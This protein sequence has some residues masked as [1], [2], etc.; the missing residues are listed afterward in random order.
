MGCPSCG[1]ENPSGARFCNSCGAPQVVACF[2]CGNGNPPASRFCNACGSSLGVVPAPAQRDATPSPQSYT[3]R[4]LAEKILANRADLEGERKQV[5]VLFADVVGSTELIR[6]RDPED[7]QRLL[8]GIVKVMME[9]VHRYE[10]TVSRLTGDGLMAM[11]GAPVAHEDHAV[12][13]CYAALA[14]LE[15]A[16]GHA[17][18]LRRSLGVTLTI[19]VGLSSGEV[20]VRAIRDDLHMDYTAMGQTVH[21]AS[22]MEQLAEP[23]TAAFTVETLALVEGYV[24][25]RALGPVPVKGLD[26]PVEIYQLLGAGQVRSRFQAAA[27]RGLTR[28]VGRQTE[29][30]ALYGALDRARGGDG[31][32]AALVGEP[33]VGKSRLVWELTHSHHV[34]GW[35]ILESGSV[36]YGKTTSYLP[37]IDLLKSYCRIETRDDARTIREKVLGK[38]LNLDESL[39]T[40]LPAI[41]T[42]LDVEV[43]DES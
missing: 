26:G 41:L 34:A 9:A 37:V 17:D 13:A 15:A 1:A 8:D 6:D 19:R 4:H 43:G 21:L 5:T 12:R 30:E 33:G 24:Q 7:A 29:L 40:T 32:V 14:M 3:P 35:T 25:V 10:G 2:G 42:L 36:S 31:Q 23:G 27:S 11:F 39:R 22:R 28:F 16:G 38:L 18:A 20:V